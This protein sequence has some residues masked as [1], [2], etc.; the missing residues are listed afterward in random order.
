MREAQIMPEG[1]IMPKGQS[2][3]EGQIIISTERRNSYGICAD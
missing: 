3:P 2:L 1:Q